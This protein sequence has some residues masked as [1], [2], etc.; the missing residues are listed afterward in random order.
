GAVGGVGAA[1]RIA[2]VARTRLE[3]RRLTA[4][5]VREAAQLALALGGFGELRLFRRYT[6]CIGQGTL[7][8][9]APLGEIAR[10]GRKADQVAI[11]GVEC[12]DQHARPEAPPVAPN[13]PSFLL[14]TAGRCRDMK[15]LLRQIRR[16]R[17]GRV[18]PSER[19]PDDLGR[20][21]P[22]NALGAGIPRCDPPL[23]VEHVNGV[24]PN[25]FDEQAEILFA[26]ANRFFGLA[27]LGQIPRDLGES[28]ELATVVTQRGDDDVGPEAR[29]VLP[30]A[31]AFILEAAGVRR[32]AQLELWKPLG[33]Q[34]GRVEDGEMLTDG[35][36]GRVAL[37][38]L[39]AG[40]PTPDIAPGIERED[41]VVG[42]ALD[43]QL[44]ER[45]ARVKRQG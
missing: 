16:D 36:L 29:A 30:K 25:T 13:T 9:R 26:N 42:Y 4:Q 21:E 22:A 6:A 27:P 39:G 7:L 43:Q 11:L 2:G 34:L 31:P 38:P 32:R 3:L 23:R 14:V 41:G 15:M 24:I 40:V 18:E 20:L 10:D 35:L 33:D 44:V 5:F 8:R 28:D 45:C 1:L 17:F 12:G 37:Q 19:P